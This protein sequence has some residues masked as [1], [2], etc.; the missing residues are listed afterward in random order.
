MRR[1][2]QHIVVLFDGF[3][4]AHVFV[5]AIHH[6]LVQIDDSLFDA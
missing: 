4:F 6:D 5:N 1:R 2:M 3:V